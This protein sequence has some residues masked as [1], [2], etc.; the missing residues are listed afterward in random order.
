MMSS[1]HKRGDRCH[2]PN[3]LNGLDL[4]SI[5]AFGEEVVTTLCEQLIVTGVPGLHFY[6]LNQSEPVLRITQNLQLGKG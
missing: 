2:N 4:A 6:S 1:L 5:K 3:S